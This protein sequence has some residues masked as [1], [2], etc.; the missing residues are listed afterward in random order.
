MTDYTVFWPG[1][2]STEVRNSN[3]AWFYMVEPLPEVLPKSRYYDH[4]CAI[5]GRKLMYKT[6][7]KYC[8]AHR[9]EG[10]RLKV[11][12][13]LQKRKLMREAEKLRLRKKV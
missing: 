13:Y 11:K 10:N 1:I 4:F 12:E 7:H 9:E 8:R 6:E 5:C 2:P 3:A